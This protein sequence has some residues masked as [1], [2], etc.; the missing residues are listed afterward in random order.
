MKADKAVKAALQELVVRG[1]EAP[2]EADEAQDAVLY[3]NLMMA[4]FAADGIALGYTSVTDLG[5]EI[6][7][8]DGALLPMIKNLA[9]SLATQFGVPVPN[10]LFLAARAGLNTMRNITVKV[11]PSRFP[12]TLPLGSGNEHDNFT[13]RHFYPDQQS[14]ILTEQSGTILLEEGT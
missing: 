9:V 14:Q 7:I 13:D 11:I 1:V 6:T 5:D 10:D 4:Q 12:S 2:I 8:P 3:M